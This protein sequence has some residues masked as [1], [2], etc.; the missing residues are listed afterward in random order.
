MFLTVRIPTDNTNSCSP[1]LK[2]AGSIS[3]HQSCLWPAQHMNDEGKIVVHEQFV[4]TVS[5]WM[6]VRWKLCQLHHCGQT[7]KAS[8][9]TMDSWVSCSWMPSFQSSLKSQRR[10]T[11]TSMVGGGWVGGQGASSQPCLDGLPACW[12]EWSVACRQRQQKSSLLQAR[13]AATAGQI[14][15][16]AQLSSPTQASYF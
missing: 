16:L 5:Q 10:H 12:P 7:R 3:C 11:I 8:Q 6:R 2:L 4:D 9:S 14:S 1:C 13:R 15:R